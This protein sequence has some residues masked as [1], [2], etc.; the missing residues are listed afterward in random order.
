MAEVSRD[1]YVGASSAGPV[2]PLIFPTAASS[3][4]ARAWI[5]EEKSNNPAKRFWRLCMANRDRKLHKQVIKD[6]SYIKSAKELGL[7]GSMMISPQFCPRLGQ[8]PLSST[9]RRERSCP[10]CSGGAP[11]GEESLAKMLGVDQSYCTMAK[12]PI[13]PHQG[14]SGETTLTFQDSPSRDSVG[15]FDRSADEF[16]SLVD[17]PDNAVCGGNFGLLA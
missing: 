12:S 16:S 6:L 5:A 2:Q 8:R 15:K 11:C 4:V 13:Q 3:G 7:N 10:W 17:L 9:F 14:S 1:T